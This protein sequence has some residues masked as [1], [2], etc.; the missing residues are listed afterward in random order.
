MIATDV[1][2]TAS[3]YNALDNVQYQLQMAQEKSHQLTTQINGYNLVL[4]VEDAKFN[5][6]RLD[7]SSL[8]ATFTLRDL[9]AI[10]LSDLSQVTR[11]L[12]ILFNQERECLE[13]I[14]RNA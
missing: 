11:E 7:F 14:M 13:A 2:I 8:K 5:L 3:L 12:A 10:A 9:R 1:E 6:D 4:N